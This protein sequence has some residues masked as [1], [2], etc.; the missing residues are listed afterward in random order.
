M[1]ITC[2]VLW[3]GSFY[4]SMPC[5]DIAK[6]HADCHPVDAPSDVTLAAGEGELDTANVMS[7]LVANLNAR[8]SLDSHCRCHLSPAGFVKSLSLEC[9]L[10]VGMA[11]DVTAG[12][13]RIEFDRLA[14][15][16][17]G[18]IA[19]LLPALHAF[20]PPAVGDQDRIR[21]TRGIFI[22]SGISIALHVA[23]VCI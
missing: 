15:L 18:L 1:I 4:E 10:A 12:V 16:V 13:D 9:F 8:P 22:E 23:E 7:A 21:Y 19:N 17:C 11:E 2:R 5:L 6:L 3:S 14:I 20:E